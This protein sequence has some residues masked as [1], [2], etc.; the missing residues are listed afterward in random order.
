VI[1]FSLVCDQGH[2]FESWFRDSSS[3]DSQAELGLISC[4]QC[5]STK[6]A[7]TMMAPQV[8]RK[9]REDAKPVAPSQPVALIS[10]QEQQLRAKVRELRAMLTE[11]SDYVGDRFAAE[12][13]KMHEGEIDHRAIYGQASGEDVRDLIEDGIDILPLPVLPDEHN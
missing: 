11:K 8:A 9:D 4:V 10:P 12:A 7:K 2:E 1:R 6:I 5:A 13:R 3:Y